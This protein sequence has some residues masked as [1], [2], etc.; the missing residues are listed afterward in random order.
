MDLT[1]LNSI[2]TL[3]SSIILGGY[4]LLFISFG[5]ARRSA[6]PR[7]LGLILFGIVIVKLY[8]YDIWLL[9]RIYRMVAFIA[10]GGL[11]LAGSYL[12]SRFRGKLSTLIR[13]TT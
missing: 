6:L 7:I 11:L 9:D 13:D 2:K 5:F 8:I 4:G 12:Y 1:A 3:I 10:L